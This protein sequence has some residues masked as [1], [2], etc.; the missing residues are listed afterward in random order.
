MKIFLKA[1]ISSLSASFFD[2]LVT[3]L[4]VKFLHADPMLGVIA[5]TVFGGLINFLIGRYWVFQAHNGAISLQGKRYLLAWTGNL[6]LNV[7]GAYILIKLFMVQYL[8]AKVT[9]SI[10]VA[11]AYNYHI[12]KKYV[13]KTSEENEKKVDDI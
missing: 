1:N 3:I 4:L 13:F 8:V 10:I 5:G 7:F 11:T 6:I 12:Q 9:T 2:Y